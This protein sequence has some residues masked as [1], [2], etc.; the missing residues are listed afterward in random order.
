[1]LGKV[2]GIVLEK[3][4]HGDLPAG[5]AIASGL[6]TPTEVTA[7]ESMAATKAKQNRTCTTILLG[8]GPIADADS[9]LVPLGS[10]G[11]AEAY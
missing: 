10:P 11:R 2:P 6:S 8:L 4:L 5:Q 3:V 9:V 7:A 1:V